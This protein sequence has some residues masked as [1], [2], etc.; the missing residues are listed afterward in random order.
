MNNY[1]VELSFNQWI[2][3]IDWRR[4]NNCDSLYNDDIKTEMESGL[5]YWKGKDKKSR[6]CLVIT[7]RMLDPKR[8]QRM[9]TFQ[10]FVLYLIESKLKELFIEM[11]NQED[12]KVNS[13][14]DRF[15]IIYDRRGLTFNHIDP[16]L[17]TSSRPLFDS[18][19]RFYGG[20]LSS[21]Y[22]VHSNIFFW[23]FFQILRPFLM[24]T[25]VSNRLILVE[26][27]D[28]LLEYFDDN[29]IHLLDPSMTITTTLSSDVNSSNSITDNNE[30]ITTPEKIDR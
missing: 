15:V 11:D 21:I 17:Q 22:I 16:N 20:F 4:K 30:T 5:A 8:P 13:I 27:R 26:T 10:K 14:N 28:D 7:G 24:I 2:Q 9:K 25:N 3:W 18:L 12:Y 23:T 6:K 29:E 19:K 1:N